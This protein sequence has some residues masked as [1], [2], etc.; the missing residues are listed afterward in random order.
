[1]NKKGFTILELIVVVTMMTFLGA[2]WYYSYSS[3]LIYVRDANRISQLSIISDWLEL[4]WQK[5]GYPQPEDKLE[6][7]LN[8]KTIWYQ[9]VIWKVWIEKIRYNAA[10]IDPKDDVY[11]TYFLSKSW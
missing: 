9:W 11:F 10:W 5:Y 1:M 7:Q 4:Y 6:I 3:Y 8:W 2:I